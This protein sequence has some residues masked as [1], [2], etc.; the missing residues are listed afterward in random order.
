MGKYTLQAQKFAALF[1]EFVG[2]DKAITCAA[3][4]EKLG[5]AERTVEGWRYGQGLP[6]ADNLAKLA[7]HLGHE[8]LNVWLLHIGFTGAVQIAGLDAEPDPRAMS[9]LAQRLVMA[10]AHV[11]QHAAK[12]DHRNTSALVIDLNATITKAAQVAARLRAA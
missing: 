4:A 3:L 2:P 8:F 12:P 5:L 7:Q 6:Q 10:A 9:E 1:R 11:M